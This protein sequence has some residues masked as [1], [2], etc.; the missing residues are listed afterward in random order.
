[1]PLRLLLTL[2]ALSSLTLSAQVAWVG[3]VYFNDEVR[4]DERS[5]EAIDLLSNGHLVVRLPSM[6]RKIAEYERLLESPDLPESRREP[7]EQS[8]R[9]TIEDRDRNNRML[10]EAFQNQYTF[11]QVW[12]VYDS[13]SVALRDGHWGG[14]FLNEELQPD[15]GI[16]FNP[17]GDFFTARIGNT[18]G[19][20]GLYAIVLGDSELKD[21]TAPFP[22][23]VQLSSLFSILEGIIVPKGADRRTYNKVTARLQNRLV[24][25]HEIS[26]RKYF[27]VEEVVVQEEQPVVTEELEERH[28]EAIDLL[29]EGHLVVRLPSMASTIAEYKQFLESPD[30]PESQRE[31]M[32]RTLLQ[33]IE[34]RDRNNR[35]LVEAFE[36]QYTFSKVWYVYDTASVALRDGYWNGIFLNKDLK[37]DSSIQ[38]YPE[39]VFF[40]ARIEQTKNNQG[41]YAIVLGNTLL[42]DFQAPFPYYAEHRGLAAGI[43]R[44]LAPEK[45]NRSSYVKTTARL[46]DELERFRKKTQRKHLRES[47]RK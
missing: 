15:Q 37:P 17:E 16:Q 27:Q 35:L 21:F 36:N 44:I 7:L 45:A 41:L 13:A 22:Y 29:H 33:A 46:Q 42:E 38:F 25:F 23:Y 2:F 40:T 47:K 28:S 31:S 4:Q 11:S 24:R 26:Y 6:A 34:D 1:M 8:I 9:Q 39:G 3:P 19:S 12:Y 14:I 5:Y 32:S 43:A 10:M 18:K 30:L 20:Q